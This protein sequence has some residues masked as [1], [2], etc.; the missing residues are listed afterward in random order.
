MSTIV[1]L[2]ILVAGVVRADAVGSAAVRNQP[3][4]ALARLEPPSGVYFGVNLDWGTDSAAAFNQRLGLQAA[5]YVQ[6]V[7]FPLSA[8]DERN[9]DGF[10][11]QVA[12]QG[13]IAVLTLEPWAG[14]GAVTPEVAAEFAARLAAYNQTNHVPVV[15][16]FA[17]EMNGSWY[18]WAQQPAAYI[19]AFQTLAAAVHT[20]APQSAMLWAPNEGSGYPF[21][22][23]Q[24][25]AKPGSADYVA[26]DTNGDGTV[27]IQDDMYAPYYPGD[28]A[29]DWV[30]LS[31]Y[32]WG[33]VYPWGKNVVPVD[34]KFRGMLTGTYRGINGTD[35]L[36]PNFY[37]E[38]VDGHG[39]PMAVVE[40]AA[41]YNTSVGGDPEQHIKQLWWRQVFD[42]QIFVDFPRLKMI[43]WF[44]WR[45]YENEVNAVVD[46]RL[47]ADPVMVQAFLADL[48]RDQLLFAP[49]LNLQPSPP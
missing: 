40:T 33:D 41:F 11:Q 30:G 32:H 36:L 46:W 37:H 39:K 17:Q 22:G 27:D 10:I 34:G 21:S 20:I 49:D 38:F 15:V 28:D 29:V 35:P 23:G 14:L 43:N 3:V 24:Y 44:E 19:Q 45:K 6:F 12:D 13:G 8:D 5:V 18:P 1:L 2:S 25:E 4:P 7:G 9:A 16:R 42:P 31:L 48:P 26:L 47:T